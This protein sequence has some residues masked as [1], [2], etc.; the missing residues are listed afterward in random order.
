MRAV[1]CGYRAKRYA[2]RQCW[3]LLGRPDFDTELR[4]VALDV[5]RL[6]RAMRDVFA[7]TMR[8]G[9]NPNARG[10][11]YFERKHQHLL[12]FFSQCERGVDI[13][14][15]NAYLSWIESVEPTYRGAATRT[16][17]LAVCEHYRRLYLAIR[18]DGVHQPLQVGSRRGVRLP[19]VYDGGNRFAIVRHLRQPS[20]ALAANRATLGIIRRF[21]LVYVESSG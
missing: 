7:Y 5:E 19:G 11:A 10:Y 8:V 9:L 2:T 16:D 15:G 6:Y 1:A 12:E 18:D 4:V 17:R 20:V 21:E 14:E 13:S 3:R